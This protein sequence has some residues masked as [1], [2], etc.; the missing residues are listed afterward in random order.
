MSDRKPRRPSAATVIALIA[1]FVAL[2]GPV[3][4][5]RLIRGSDIKSSTITSRHIKNSSLTGSDV[6]N[7]ALKTADLATST[8]TFLRQTPAGSINSASIADRTVANADLAPNSVGQ[9]KIINGS[10]TGNELAAN[11]VSGTNVAD[12]SLAAVDVARFHGTFDLDVPALDPQTCTGL[13]PEG[14]APQAQNFDLSKD[15]IVGSPPAAWP[16]ALTFAIHRA[17][18]FP[19]RI[20]VIVCNPTAAP[21]DPPSGS[22]KYAVLTF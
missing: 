7:R 12:G 1:L 18:N 8:L 13:N 21:I 3:N 19:T 11:A 9:G 14:L 4:A 20:R 5:A 6:K 22:F 10:V 2:D 16:D 17:A 15:L